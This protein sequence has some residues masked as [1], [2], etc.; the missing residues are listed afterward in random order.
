MVR[1]W[2]GGGGLV[3]EDKGGRVRVGE[4]EEMEGE[5]RRGE[6]GKVGGWRDG[7]RVGG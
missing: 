1:G 3:G 6:R 4:G 2:R 5:G 7:G